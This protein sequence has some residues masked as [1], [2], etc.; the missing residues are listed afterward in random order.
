M[1]K[2]LAILLFSAAIGLGFST[3]QASSSACPHLFEASQAPNLASSVSAKVTVVCYTD[4]A[5]ANSGVTKGPLWSAEHLTKEQVALAKNVTRKDAFHADKNVPAADRAEL[6]D[7]KGSGY[8]RGHMT[9]SGDA[10]SA[11]SQY[12]TFTL[13]NIVPQNSTLNRGKWSRI[14]ASVRAMATEMDELYVI[15]GPIFDADSIPTI[16][17]NRVAVPK[18]VWKAVSFPNGGGAGAYRCTNAA[19]VTCD[20]VSIQVITDATGVTIFPDLSQYDRQHPIDL[21]L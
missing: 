14:E 7:Y 21:P 9:P 3:A 2:R 15:T 19:P 1:L 8:D 4:Y 17:D 11:D 10:P 13:A 20:V 6:A 16:G 12:E 18:Y 5:L